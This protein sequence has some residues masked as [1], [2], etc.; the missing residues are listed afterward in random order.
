MRYKKKTVGNTAA[1]TVG[2]LADWAYGAEPAFYAAAAAGLVIGLMIC[3]AIA[4]ATTTGTARAG[5]TTM[6]ALAAGAV[7]GSTVG[8]RILAMIGKTRA[9]RRDTARWPVARKPDKGT[10]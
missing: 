7:L 4:L 9:R 10:R 5:G 2:K 6:T 1:A 8:L 3:G